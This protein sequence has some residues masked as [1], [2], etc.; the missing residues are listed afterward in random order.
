MA[1][2]L[3]QDLSLDPHVLHVV[4]TRLAPHAA[5]GAQGQFG[6]FAAHNTHPR[7]TLFIESSAQ[8]LMQPHGA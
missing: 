5:C 3:P 4:Q 7:P 2:R 8:G 6:M 1:H